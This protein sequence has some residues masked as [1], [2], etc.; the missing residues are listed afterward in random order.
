MK[1]RLSLVSLAVA[2]GLTALGCAFPHHQYNLPP[3]A[4]LME[5][6]PGVGGPGPGVLPPTLPPAMIPVSM[7][8]VQVLFARPEGMQI[9]WDVS[10][11]SP[12]D[13]TPL[14]VP[15]RQNFPQNGMY[16]MK[17]TNIP[18]REGT[19]LYPTVEIGPTTPRTEAFLAHNA[20]PI[21]FTEEDFDQVLAGNFVTK[22]IYLPD[23]EFQEL[24]LAG[25]ETLVSTRLEPGVDPITEAD[26]RGSILAVVRLGNKDV[27]LGGGDGGPGGFASMAGYGGG[28]MD[29]SCPVPYGNTGLVPNYVSGITAPQYGMPYVGTPIGLPGPPH[30]PLGVPA[31]MQR[32]V[33]T[34]HT[35]FNIPQPAKNFAIHLRQRPGYSYPKPV[36]KVHIKEQMIHASPGYEQPHYDM[37]ERIPGG[38][39]YGYNAA[40]AYGPPGD[41]PPG[42]PGFVPPAQQ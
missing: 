32:H 25:V 27:E 24:A 17:L 5:P 1:I 9:R 22:V 15:G 33:M 26:R 20:I 4:Q 35:H 14:I 2:L 19:E 39:P 13:S 12:F 10:G 23:P 40:A 37:H 7:P 21:Q 29:P 28:M 16:R 8:S 11:Y 41:C 6:G 30:I 18:G 42:S 31:G 38:A 36:T 3:A 34:N